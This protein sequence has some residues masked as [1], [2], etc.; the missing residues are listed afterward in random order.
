M[1]NPTEKLQHEIAELCQDLQQSCFA[2]WHAD[3][4]TLWSDAPFG[5]S[6][7]AVFPNNQGGIH[8]TCKTW[9]VHYPTLGPAVYQQ[10]TVF[11]VE[12]K[13]LPELRKKLDTQLRQIA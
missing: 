8:A 10:R 13:T 11:E 6:E 5:G 12:A 1:M 9:A 3:R 2:Q 4:N 7:L